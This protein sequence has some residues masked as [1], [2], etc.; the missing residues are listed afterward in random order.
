MHVD[1][2]VVHVERFTSS[3]VA[4]INMACHSCITIYYMIQGGKSKNGH[5][6]SEGVEL[7]DYL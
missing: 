4:S 6:D 1:V 5:G 2:R 3:D 7:T